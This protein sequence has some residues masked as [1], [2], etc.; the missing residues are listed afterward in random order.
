MIGVIVAAL[1]AR[2]TAHDWKLELFV[3]G[4]NGGEELGREERLVSDRNKYEWIDYDGTIK[5]LSTKEKVSYAEERNKLLVEHKKKRA[6]IEAE[7]VKI[8]L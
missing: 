8:G 1:A 6:A 7:A 3:G 2:I 4:P 5:E